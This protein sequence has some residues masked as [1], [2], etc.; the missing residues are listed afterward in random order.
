MDFF[1]KFGGA[2]IQGVG[3]LLGGGINA[4]SQSSAN[5]A[6]MR[7]LE[8]QNQF[9]IDQWNRENEYNS[10]IRQ[11]E[12]LKAAGLN[13]NLVY[14]EG[15]TGN[16]SSTVRSATPAP[17]R[18]T[19]A[20]SIVAN[21]A[22]SVADIIQSNNQFNAK[23]NQEREI[24]AAQLAT[25]QFDAET[26]R[27]LGEKDVEVKDYNLKFAK[28]T[29]DEQIRQLHLSNDLQEVKINNE[30]L[31]GQL[32]EKQIAGQNLA[33]KKLEEELKIKPLEAQLLTEK[34]RG[35]ILS[36]SLAMD[37]HKLNSISIEIADKTKDANIKTALAQAAT[38]QEKARVV[39]KY[40]EQETMLRIAEGDLKLDQ[41]YD[42]SSHHHF[43][44]LGMDFVWII[45]EIKKPFGH[46]KPSNYSNPAYS[47]YV[48]KHR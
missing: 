22:K 17:M 27:M 12:R 21:G 8:R 29:R 15:V 10:P 7:L 16:S 38:E 48:G 25:Q 14:G 20:G 31:G 41:V 5:R 33:N 28:D 42:D 30:K 32:T 3:S 39:A 19:D 13:P 4:L 26:R 24:A 1:S 36:N 45:D 23:L 35:Q 34:I 11:M 2:L 40:F 18:A 9:N 44:I 46:G 43:D 47:R 37:T 6:N